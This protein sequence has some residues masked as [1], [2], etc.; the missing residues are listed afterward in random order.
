MTAVLLT[1]AGCGSD[2]PTTA[3]PVAQ[4]PTAQPS[5]TTSPSPTPVPSPTATP[6][7]PYEGDPAVAALRTY[8]AAVAQAVNSSDLQLPALL[9]SATAERAA[10]HDEI[11]GPAVGSYY[12]APSPV[13]VLGV[14][15]VSETERSIAVCSPESGFLLDAPGGSPT[16]PLEVLGGRFVVVLEGGAWK[17]DDAVGDDA[18]SCAGVPLQGVPA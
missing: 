7:S 10:V 13:A 12:P 2:E 17:V 6:L 9:A 16:E 18:V 8:L 3:A 14:Q 1:A 5:P 15:V 11:Y 4:A